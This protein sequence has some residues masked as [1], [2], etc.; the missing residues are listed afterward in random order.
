MSTR[1]P[2]VT[3]VKHHQKPLVSGPLSV[4][5][6]SPLTTPHRR[7]K[8]EGEACQSLDWSKDLPERN[9]T[10]SYVSLAVH[11]QETNAEMLAFVV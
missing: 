7:P 8:H 9:D 1:N 6:S 10:S 11:H 2:I 3:V 4:L 5:K